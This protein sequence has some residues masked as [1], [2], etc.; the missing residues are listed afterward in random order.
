[1]EDLAKVSRWVLVLTNA[2]RARHGV[3]PVHRCVKLDE[4]AAFHSRTMAMCG[5]FAHEDP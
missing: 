5:F 1:M 4:V 2:E 3:P